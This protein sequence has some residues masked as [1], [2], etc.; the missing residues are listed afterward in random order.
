VKIA[1]T[2]IAVL[3]LLLAGAGFSLSFWRGTK[4]ILV[5]EIL[6][7][8]WLIGAGLVSL[9]LALGGI[10]LS[11]ALLIALVAVVC[12][13]LGF[14]GWKRLQ[15]GLCIETG[16]AQVPPWEKWLTLLLLVPIV[17]FTYANF[18]DA[19]LWDGLVNWEAKARHA[20]VAGGSLPSSYFAD[21]TR[22]RFHPTYP[23]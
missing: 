17:Y 18:R 1:G 12:L 4:S 16:L 22:I 23:L 5:A 2:L 19:L 7:L 11:G 8:G 21:A 9:F 10:A 6:G 20:F 15:G 13:L 3:A 14:A